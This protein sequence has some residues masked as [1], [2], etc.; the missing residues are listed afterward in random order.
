MQLSQS[1]PTDKLIVH[2]WHRV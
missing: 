2:P 1:D